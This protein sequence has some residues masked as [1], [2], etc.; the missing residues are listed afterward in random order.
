M[1]AFTKHLSDLVDLSCEPSPSS[2]AALQ[3]EDHL[4]LFEMFWYGLTENF[5]SKFPNCCRNPWHKKLFK[6]AISYD[7]LFEELNPQWPDDDETQVAYICILYL[8]YFHNIAYVSDKVCREFGQRDYLAILLRGLQTEKLPTKFVVIMTGI[9]YN[10]CRKVPANRILCKDGIKTLE[11]LSES[12]VAEI[13]FHA[14][15]SVAY[16]IDNSD[17]SK[18]SLKKSC[19][20]FILNALK[21]ALKDPE[22]RGHGY[23]VEEL[24]Q[25]LHQLAINDNNKRLIAEHGGIPL[26]ETVLVGDGGTDEEKRLVAQVIWQLGFIEENKL[27][28]RQRQQLMKGKSLYIKGEVH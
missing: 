1:K 27:K 15:L 20:K 26:L 25:D 10:C 5:G 19:T 11:D 28:I 22:R 2:Y 9:I 23:A 16:I 21:K 18:F 24:V 12:P 17:V 3:S 7:A 8:A 4:D 13:Q 14:L 6:R